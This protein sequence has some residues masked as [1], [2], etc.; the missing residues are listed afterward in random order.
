MP[1]IRLGLL[2]LLAVAVM[3]LS[4]AVALAV[5]VD[6]ELVLAVDVSRS[7]DGDEY[8]LQ[9][10]GYAEA[11]A[12]PAVI[13]A[14]QSNPLRQIAVT[15]V[16]W[17]GSDFQKV[18]VPWTVLSDEES[19]TLFGEAI[20]RAPRSFWGWT[21]IS[22]AIDFSAKLFG[23]AGLKG[24]RRVID[25]SGDGINNSG[26]PAEL[27]RD[28]AVKAGIVING[29]V[30]MNDRPTPG[31][32]PRPQPPLDDYFRGSVIGGPGAFVIAIED[33]TTFAYAIVNKLIKE[34]A[35]HPPATA[36]AGLVRGVGNSSSAGA[37]ATS[38]GDEREG[39]E[40]L[41]LERPEQN[42]PGQ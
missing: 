13:R 6:L 34:I 32:M 38:F 22:G 20:M 10:Q 7:I 9:K 17:G 3:A 42:H 16:E 2:R 5:E 39:S 29:L 25:V 14:I 31:V 4:P 11:F 21:S 35:G 37:P 33:F 36:H 30:I 23:A 26:R 28:E 12:H 8:A 15:V 27:A 24:T 41:V 18:V 40:L 19:G 1:A